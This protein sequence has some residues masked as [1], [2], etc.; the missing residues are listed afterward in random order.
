[1]PHQLG[2]REQRPLESRRTR[3][4]ME[5]S[6]PLRPSSESVDADAEAEEEEN[7]DG[8]TAAHEGHGHQ[9]RTLRPRTATRAAVAQLDCGLRGRRQQTQ[10]DSSGYVALLEAHA[11]WE[12]T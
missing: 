8:D 1:M 5:P 6:P 3:R 9:P 7:G 4:P 11:R 2:E 12:L 10:I